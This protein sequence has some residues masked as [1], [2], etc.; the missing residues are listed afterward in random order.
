[1][2]WQQLIFPVSSDDAE[3][4]SEL[5]ADSGAAAVTLKDAADQPLFEP[6]VGTTPLW[7]NTLVIALFD[8]SVALGPIITKMAEAW[9]PR[10]LPEPQIQQLPDQVWERA[11][12]DGFEPMQFGQRLW[13]VPSWFD[14][15]DPNAVN[16]KLDPGLAFGTGTHPTTRLCLEWLDGHTIPEVVIDYGCGSGILAIAAAKLGAEQ[17]E[18]IDTDP[19][20]LEA[21]IENGRRNGIADRL[22][23]VLPAQQSGQPAR[24]LLANILAGPLIELA[25]KLAQLVTEGGDIV[26]SG[27]LKEQWA[28]VSK[29]Y[30]PWFKM[31]PP[32]EIDGWIRLHG[33]RLE[34]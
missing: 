15:P 25:P 5:L 6:P 17:I 1:M 31:Q 23:S 4:L 29:A 13:I 24:L 26:L 19:Q 8:E 3:L 28:D 27:I 33:L 11:W 22:K 9:G 2:L 32:D 14:E 20:A 21:T 34:G 18:C 10:Q 30:E 7:S 16:I 12:M